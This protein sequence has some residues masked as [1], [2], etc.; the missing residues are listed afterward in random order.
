LDD[1]QAFRE[2]V[3]EL[4]RVQ[5]AMADVTNSG[6]ENWKREFIDLRRQLQAQIGQVARAASACRGLATSDV[7]ARDIQEALSRMRTAVALHQANWPAVS[8]DPAD[9]GYIKSS[10]SVRA[11]NRAFIDLAQQV[12]GR[13]AAASHRQE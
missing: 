13:G 9:P 10:A 5:A 1:L 3:A 11:A 4:E 2:A 6:G 8:I 12:L 7:L